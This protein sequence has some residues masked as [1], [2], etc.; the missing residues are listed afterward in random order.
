MPWI[1]LGG[2]GLIAVIFAS[3]RGPS[4]S[5]ASQAPQYGPFPPPLGKFS[6]GVPYPL[7]GQPGGTVTYM[8]THMPTPGSWSLLVFSSSKG[9]MSHSDFNNEG[10][11]RDIIAQLGGGELTAFLYDPSRKLIASAMPKAGIV[12]HSEPPPPGI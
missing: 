8:L 5:Q 10:Y 9:F 11:P 6:Y 2:L 3:S 1:L 12:P 7:A 4:S